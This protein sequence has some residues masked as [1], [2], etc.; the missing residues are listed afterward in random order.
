MRNREICWLKFGIE[1]WKSYKKRGKTLQFL[2]KFA[3]T[4]YL[5]DAILKV[6][7]NTKLLHQTVNIFFVIRDNNPMPE[8]KSLSELAEEFTCYF[9]NKILTIR[10]KAVITN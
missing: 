2:I 3:K 8:S 5:F 1:T 6:N 9:L 7:G 10:T 4:Q